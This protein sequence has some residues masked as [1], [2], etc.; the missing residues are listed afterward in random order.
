M[1]K[2]RN[3]KQGS[4]EESKVEANSILKIKLAKPIVER[5]SDNPLDYFTIGN[6]EMNTPIEIKE[7]LDNIEK[8][9]TDDKSMPLNEKDLR[10]RPEVENLFGIYSSLKDQTILSTIND[11]E[12]KK[13]FR[14]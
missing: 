9:K 1:K 14:F 12:K 11:F 6:T 3:R 5:A 8:A 10:N 13:F 7:I 4:K 2:S